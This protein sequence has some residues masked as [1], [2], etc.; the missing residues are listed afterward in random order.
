MSDIL[1]DDEFLT[2]KL[3]HL[4]HFLEEEENEITDILV[5][6]EILVQGGSVK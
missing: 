3:L 6:Q 2:R 4:D 1:D 5:C